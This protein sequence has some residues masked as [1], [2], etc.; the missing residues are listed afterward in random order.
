MSVAVQ[1]LVASVVG[2]PHVSV[3]PPPTIPKFKLSSSGAAFAVDG[4]A[5][6]TSATV[7]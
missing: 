4:V 1:P 6:A 3:V 2:S 7:R 5:K